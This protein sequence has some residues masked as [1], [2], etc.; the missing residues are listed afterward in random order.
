MSTRAEVYCKFEGV[1]VCT[2]GCRSRCTYVCMSE[3]VR[4]RVGI[5]R[6]LDACMYIFLVFLGGRSLLC[7]LSAHCRF[8][9]IRT[10]AKVPVGHTTSFVLAK[11]LAVT[12]VVE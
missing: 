9:T 10:R 3:C 12:R 1:R 2:Y 5:S 8:T 11:S 6:W 7:W 4:L